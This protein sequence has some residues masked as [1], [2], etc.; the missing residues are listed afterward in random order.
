[1][2]KRIPKILFNNIDLNNPK[3]KKYITDALSDKIIKEIIEVNQLFIV[4]EANNVTRSFWNFRQDI[5]YNKSL[6]NIAY[7]FLF[8]FW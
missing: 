2:K 6:I 4:D 1:M 8:V 7:L 5:S 3:E